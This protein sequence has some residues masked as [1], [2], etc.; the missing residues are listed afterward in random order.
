MSPAI[1]L[2]LALALGCK[3]RGPTEDPGKGL[4]SASSRDDDGG[5]STPKPTGFGHGPE[6]AASSADGDSAPDETE[7]DWDVNA[8]P[9]PKTSVKIDVDSGTWMSLDV[10]PDG[11]TIVFDLLGDLYTMPITGG[12][13]KSLTSGMAWDMQPTFSPDGQWIAF[14]SD[15]GGGDNIWVLPAAGG[16]AKAVT[17]E[18][19]RLLNSPAWTPDGKYIVARKHFT[20]GRSL[21]AGEMWLY[22]VAGGSGLQMTAKPNDQKDVGEPAFSPDGRYLYY[23]QDVTPGKTFQY[24]KDPHAGIYAIKRLDR[25]EQRTETFVRGPG[26]A[27]RPTPS[28][29]G[30]SL[31]YVRRLGLSTALYVHD[32]TTGKESVVYT[33]L[34]RDMQETWAV[35]GVYPAMAWTP[36]S[37]AIVCWAGGKIRRIDVAS[38]QAKVIPFRVQDTREV[39][40]SLR[41]P[42]E[43]HPKRFHTKMLRW[44][45]V[46]PDGAFALYQAI[47]HLYLRDMKTGRVRRVTRDDDVFEQHPSFSRDGK[48]IVYTTWNDKT[49]GEIRVVATRGGRPKT[50]T[51]QPG[52]YTDPVMSPDGASVVYRKVGGG[53]LRSR[54][55]SRDTG[56][57]LVSSKGGDST[58]V[59]RDGHEAQ[60]G[61]RS[62]RVFFSAFDEDDDTTSTVLKSAR[63]D[64]SKVREHAKGEHIATFAV[65]PDESWLAYQERFHVYVTPFVA[66]GK[67]VTVGASA[68]GVPQAKVTRDAGEY[69]HWSGDSATLHWALG[70]ELFTRDVKDAFDFLAGSPKEALKP[71]TKG[72][73]IG[74]TVDS[75]APTGTIALTGAR[76]VTMNGDEVIEGGTIVLKGDRIAAVGA[77]VEI[78]KGATVIDAS[79]TTIIPGL[80]DVHAHG[81]Q[82]SDGIIPQQNWLHLATLAFGV[83]TVH[84]PSNDTATIF[85]AAELARAGMVTAPRIFSTGTILY[86]AKTSFT[87]Q[88]DSLEDARTHLRRMKAVGAFSVKSYNQP[89]RNQRQQIVVAARELSMMVVPEGGSLFQHN[90]TMVAD[91]HTGVEH[92]IPVPAVYDDVTQFWGGTAVGYTPTT[93]VGYGGIWGENY[94]YAHTN[95]FEHKRLRTFVPRD[96]IEPRSRRRIL[97]SRGDWNHMR[98]AKATKR[99]LDAGVGVQIGAHGQREG[100]AAHWELWM[101]VQGG[102]T[103]HEAL[104]AGTRGG[105]HYL[106]L[107][108][109]IGTL[110][111]GKLADLVVIEGNP[112]DDIRV[113]DQVRYTMVGGRLYDAATMNQIAPAAT[114][115]PPLYFE[116]EDGSSGH[117]TSQT[118]GCSCH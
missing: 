117:V 84:D 49:L 38:R 40:E 89:R 47:G 12:D 10:S 26:G 21:G 15:Q 6:A 67:A 51:T 98:I 66:V 99:L 70:P 8:P 32:L 34:E 95:V 106:G 55:W 22:H 31:A 39:L 9:G 25:T 11:K 91:G 35:H 80:V 76:I 23:S 17:K 71:P 83:T 78:P 74:F 108:G 82:G 33:Q 96:R 102:M 103:P 86:G 92:A 24:N 73:D 104:R 105:A 58:L 79:G 13:A 88:V 19:F 61:K 81:S 16:E 27:I 50:L 72:I 93:G 36:D 101:F 4:S 37:S 14:T 111:A 48:S 63:L 87:A 107:D 59:T 43:V 64:G 41:F 118:Q 85:A 46:S 44:V 115:R 1:L 97:A 112:L 60:F 100:L 5:V 77:N 90:M 20:A 3:V 94:W 30:R 28:P 69:L 57:Y 114:E 62:D 29:D 56:L 75:D 42:I 52:H 65:S 7:A 110:E 68:K 109:D 2:S 18:D 54:L 45:S 53:G 116:L 113:S